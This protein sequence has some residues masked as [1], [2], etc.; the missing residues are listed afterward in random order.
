MSTCDTVNT[1]PTDHSVENDTPFEM[2][3]EAFMNIHHRSVNCREWTL[4]TRRGTTL[5][6]EKHL[7]CTKYSC[8][9]VCMCAF[10][11]KFKCVC[12]HSHT[13]DLNTHTQTWRVCVLRSLYWVVIVLWQCWVLLRREWRLM[14]RRGRCWIDTD[15]CWPWQRCDT[16]SGSRSAPTHFLSSCPMLIV[17]WRF[18]QR[19]YTH[20]QNNNTVVLVMAT[21]LRPIKDR[22]NCRKI[23]TFIYVSLQIRM[24]ELLKIRKLNA[25]L[26]M[27]ICFYVFIFNLVWRSF[28]YIMNKKSLSNLLK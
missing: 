9:C 27:N 21:D 12:I 8:I 20:Y 5:W 25:I 17:A 11:W 4:S 18:T 22:C 23:V 19:E 1:C 26:L 3:K 2:S 28:N 15:V 24:L 13:Q 7:V 6:H 14:R 16:P 10:A